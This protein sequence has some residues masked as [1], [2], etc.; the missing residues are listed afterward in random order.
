VARLNREEEGILEPPF[1]EWLTA[2]LY[3]LAGGEKLWIPRLLSIMFWVLGG[4][5]L[6]L[7]AKRLASDTAALCTLAFYLFLP[8]GVSASRSFQ[9]DPLMVMMLLTS[10]FAILQHHLQRSRWMVIVAAGSSAVAILIKP[11][12]LFVIFAAFTSLAISRRGTRRTLTNRDTWLF[13]TLSVLPAIG[14]YGYGMLES[15]RLGN[16]LPGQASKTFL[17]HLLLQPLFWHGW[18]VQIES[19]IG[20]ASLLL[21]L[22]GL[23]MYPR[24]SSKALLLGL[25][26]GYAALGLTFTFHISTHDYYQMQLIPIVALSIGPLGAMLFHR[27]GNVANRWYVKAA[28]SAVLM[29]ALLLIIR[30][31]KW[32]L[33]TNPLED[34][35]VAAEVGEVVRHSTR[36]IILDGSWGLPLRYLGEL[37]GTT[38]PL[39]TYKTFTR[40]RQSTSLPE[41]LRDMISQRAA[42]Y[43]V[44]ELSQLDLQPDLKE[45]LFKEFLVTNHNGKYIIFKLNQ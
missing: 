34:V 31:A 10:M 45:L 26:A 39:A 32:R 23:W 37:A 17:P 12:C 11:V 41:R 30:D 22:L 8:Y 28:I 15:I 16:N 42:E 27:L 19:V 14:Y 3:R 44:V 36:T 35:N 9:P 20:R 6:H 1:L 43:F 18:L 2:I 24:R 29:L 13:F 25:W 7:I 5:P 21:S 33:D 40:E 4:V 38:W